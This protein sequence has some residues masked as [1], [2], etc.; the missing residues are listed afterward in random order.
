MQ[1][2]LEV[3]ICKGCNLPK[4]I[5]NKGKCLCFICNSKRLAKTANE[6]KKKRIEQ[7]RIA[8]PNELNK[9]FKDYWLTHPTKCCFESGKQIKT[10]SKGN[11]HHLLEKSKYPQFA[12]LKDNMVILTWE[13]HN[14]WHMLTD[15]ER[16]IK[17]PTTYQ[18]YLEIKEKYLK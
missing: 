11:L 16:A 1:I 8:N 10:Y 4:T 13:Y 5:T 18:R 7:G 14:I 9:F 3:K 12:L 17:M 2:K 15:I 6:R